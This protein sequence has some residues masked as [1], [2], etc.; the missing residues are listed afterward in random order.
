MLRFNVV[1]PTAG[2][3]ANSLKPPLSPTTA[4]QLHSNSALL[5]TLL[6]FQFGGQKGRRW[7]GG[8]WVGESSGVVSVPYYNPANTAC[9]A[10]SGGSVALGG[11]ARGRPHV[12]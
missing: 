4:V 12:F 6:K 7:A 2:K 3:L 8:G 9:L 10:T 1:V 5:L 11:S